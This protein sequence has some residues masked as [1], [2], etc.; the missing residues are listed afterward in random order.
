MRPGRSGVTF[1]ALRSG[2]AGC[3]IAHNRSRAWNDKA[4]GVDDLVGLTVAAETALA[5]AFKEGTWVVSVELDPPKGGTLDALLGV[6][7]RLRESGLVQFVDVND[8]PMARARMN[9]LMASVAIEREAGIETI[10]HLTPRDSTVMG[11][12]GVLLGAHAQ[13][14]AGITPAIRRR[15]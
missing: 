8:N 14:T 1:R 3:A 10:P 13:G 5:R 7:R 11:L 15:M 6:A 2:Q 12:E 9:A 4:V